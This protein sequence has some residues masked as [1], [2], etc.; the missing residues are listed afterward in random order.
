MDTSM[1]ATG[2][3][4]R[5]YPSQSAMTTA[6][7]LRVAA[8]SIA[9]YDYLL[10]LPL[11][12][13]LYKSSH[14]NNPTSLTL[15][16]LIRYSSVVVL[17]LSNVGFL[18]PEFTPKA[19][20][21]YFY[22]IPVFKVIQLMVSQAI[23][24]IRTYGISL[25]KVWVGRTVIMAYL[26]VIGYEWVSTLAYRRPV[27]ASPSGRPDGDCLVSNSHPDSPIATWSMYFAAML[28][29]CLILSIAAYYL[30]RMKIQGM[31]TMS[32]LVKILIYDGLAY[33]VALTAVNVMNIILFRQVP[34]AIQT[35]GSS[36]GFATIGIMSQRLLIRPRAAREERSTSS[37]VALPVRAPR[38]IPAATS[39]SQSDVEQRVLCI[40]RTARIDTSPVS[41]GDTF[42]FTLSPTSA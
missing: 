29:D 28:Y 25:R 34:D 12:Y 8:M 15:F 23:L 32:K 1:L 19:C 38:V 5:I 17:V 42:Y 20:G 4:V 41:G 35:A 30:L 22:T 27:M 11:E 3:G 13:R 40:E 2:T 37:V 18:D 14:R 21:H 26:V 10:T 9:A 39:F 36:F 33:I 16:I 7:C 24:A 31:S 6:T